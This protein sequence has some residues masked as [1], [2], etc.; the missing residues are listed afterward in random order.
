M[1]THTIKAGE[2][3]ILLAAKNGLDS[4]E[5]ILNDPQNASHKEK[6]D[7]PCVINTGDA[8]FIP[9]K[10]LKQQPSAIDNTHPFKIK[11]PKGWLRL[12]VKDADG[13]PFSGKKYDLYVEGVK[14]AGTLPDDGVIE[15]AISITATN[16]T[17]KVWPDESEQPVTWDL[18]IGHKNPLT[19][20]SGVQQRLNNLGFECGEPDGVVDD[21]TTAAVKAFQARIGVETTGTIDDDL[22]TKLKAY[23]DN[24]SDEREQDAAAEES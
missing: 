9:D 8:I 11:R 16:G 6:S 13:A 2:N 18:M 17:L 12:A 15:V 23:Y 24:A 1:P 5:K 21:D 7:D 14:A 19:E 10:T 22:R 4:W 3:L 20:I